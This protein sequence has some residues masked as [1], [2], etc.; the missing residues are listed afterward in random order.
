MAKAKRIVLVTTNKRGVF[1]GELVSHKRTGEET[2]TCKLKN[3]RMA[4]YWSADCKGIL[5]LCS[6][7]PTANC[8]ISK[9]AP[10]IT[11]EG[12]HSIMEVSPEAAAA[13]ERAP[14]N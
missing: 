6:D 13:W 1:C 3:V 11:L 9:K 12:V 2:L 7:G 14:W 5:G 10:G 8:R 4:V